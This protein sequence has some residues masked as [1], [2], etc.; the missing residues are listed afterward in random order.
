MPNEE[1]N[2]ALDQKLE[3]H[4]ISAASLVARV[5]CNKLKSGFTAQVVE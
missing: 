3:Y 1:K 2:K 4:S 5:F